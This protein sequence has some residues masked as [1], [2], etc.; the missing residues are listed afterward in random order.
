[1]REMIY[2]R[3]ANFAKYKEAEVAGEAPRTYRYGSEPKRTLTQ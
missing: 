3:A 1:M 2:T